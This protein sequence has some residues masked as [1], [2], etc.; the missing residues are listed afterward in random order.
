MFWRS[1]LILPALVCSSNWDWDKIDLGEVRFPESFLWGSAS[2]E[3]QIS[4]AVHLPNCQW[5]EWEKRGHPAIKEGQTSG[6]A[7]DGWNR[8]EEDANLLKDIGLNSYR[9]SVDWSAI[10]PREG[11]FNRGA[12]DHYRDVLNALKDRGITP[13]ITLHH[14]T[15][16]T[17]FENKGAFEKR[18][19]VAYFVRF[20]K[21]VFSE[22]SDDVELWCTINEPTVIALMGYILGEFPPGKTGIFLAAEVL[23]NMLFAHVEV[24]KALKDMKNGDNCQIGIVHSYLKF[25]PYNGWNP[26]EALPCLFFTKNLHETVMDFFKTGEFSSMLLQRETV[27]DAPNSFDFFGLNYYSRAVVGMQ[28]SLSDF[29]HATCFPGEV[30]TDMPY[31]S[32][33]EGFYQALV[34]CGE[35]GKPVY[36]TENGI[37]DSKDDRRELFIRRYLYALSEAIKDGVDV[38]GYFYWSLIDNFEWAEGWKMKFGLYECNLETG[39]R[40]LRQ[41]SLAYRNIVA[42]HNDVSRGAFETASAS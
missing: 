41:G 38:R 34:D 42:T 6:Q 39:E 24:Y 26:I 12:I 36:V 7:I 33:P 1:L 22:L 23:N 16:P 25:E 35:L 32:H 4:G 10:E 9:F 17:W 31:A 8:Y 2:S 11:E 37:A 29:L 5:A 3:Y 19:N 30:M 15:H 27:P 40:T 28:I 20:A 21:F 18:E 14:F 13:M